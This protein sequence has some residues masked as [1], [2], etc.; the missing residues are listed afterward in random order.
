MRVRSPSRI[1]AASKPPSRNRDDVRLPLVAI[2][3]APNVGKSRLFNRLTGESSIVHDRPG[4]TRDW[5][6]G[7]C[8]WNGRRFRVLETG[9]WV[10]G[11]SDEMT[12]GVERQV[13]RAIEKATLLLFVVDGRT[14]LTPLDQKLGSLFRK[15][16]RPLLLA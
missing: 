1:G 14:G 5:V 11:E 9:G 10:P 4:V 7:T 12:R 6:A 2:V 13:L 15:S 16:S 8:D 3:G